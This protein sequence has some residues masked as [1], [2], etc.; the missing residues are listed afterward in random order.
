MAED[1]PELYSILVQDLPKRLRTVAALQGYFEAIYG[2]TP[3]GGGDG[4]GLS[5]GY[6]AAPLLSAPGELAERPGATFDVTVA[7]DCKRLVK[8]QVAAL[9]PV[10]GVTAC[11]NSVALPPPVA[12]VVFDVFECGVC[13]RRPSRCE[14]GWR[15][16]W[17]ETVEQARSA[18]GAAALAGTLTV[19][20]RTSWTSLTPRLSR[21]RQS[22]WPT[23]SVASTSGFPLTTSGK[24]RTPSGMGIAGCKRLCPFVKPLCKR[25]C[26]GC[27][28]FRR[29]GRACSFEASRPRTTRPARSDRFTR[30]TR[31][32]FRFSAGCDAGAGGGRV[33]TCDERHQP[34]RCGIG[35][36]PPTERLR[37][38][39]ESTTA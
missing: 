16:R 14:T 9:C 17:R 7:I 26:P 28:R 29:A 23:H 12:I 39:R 1:R 32:R 25:L 30:L 22:G 13:R 24:R 27:P 18:S 10:G 4:G 36:Q 3:G 31:S 34:A 38:L 33:L 20:R 6:G 11:C 21:S 5:A 2:A 8:L 35:R 19:R 37:H 15:V